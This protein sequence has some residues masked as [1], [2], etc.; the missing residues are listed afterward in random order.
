MYCP[1]CNT[2]YVCPCESC[3][4]RNPTKVAWLRIGDDQ[5]ACY[6]CG[7][8]HHIEEWMNIEYE[9]YKEKKKRLSKA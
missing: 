5:E 3:Q 4:K 8:T 9:Q 2:P 6:N 7:L 1:K